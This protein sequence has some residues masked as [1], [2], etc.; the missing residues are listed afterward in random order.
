MN[1]KIDK[2]KAICESYKAGN[3]ISQIAKAFNL[4]HY[5]ITNYLRNYFEMFYGKPFL[6]YH[7]R[8]NERL[9]ELYEEYNKIYVQKLYTR[10]QICRI[11]KCNVNEL[12]AM[13]KQYNL[14]NQWL[15]T[16][17]EQVS[18]ANVSKEFMK[19]IKDFIKKYKYKSVRDLAMQAINEFMLY[20]RFKRGEEKC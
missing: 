13:F 15:Q 3:T 18:L 2:A 14:H 1:R 12:E 6:S 7:E 17:K 10:A 16:Y 20:E 11:L 19:S 8:K 5:Q 9:K 4:P